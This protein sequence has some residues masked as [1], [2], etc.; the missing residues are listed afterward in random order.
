MDKSGL[1]AVNVS[2]DVTSLLLF[3]LL[4]GLNQLSSR[5][6]GDLFRLQGLLLDHPLESVLLTEVVENRVFVVLALAGV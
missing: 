5:G 1:F 4:L 6:L 2:Q 3:I